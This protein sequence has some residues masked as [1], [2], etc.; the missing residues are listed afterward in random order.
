M[1]LQDKREKLWSAY[2]GE[3]C[4]AAY[5][6]LVNS[7]LPLVRFIVSRLNFK[8]PNHLEQEDLVSYGI[9][10]L[11]EAIKKF[12]WTRGVKFETYA[13][14]RIRGA[15]V[16][17]LR[18]EQ[19]APRSVADKLKA[20]QRAYQKFESEGIT[21]VS[22]EQLAEEMGISLE[23]LRDTMTEISQLSVV[24]L[25]EFLHGQEVDSISRAD[26]I[27]DPKSPNPAARVLEE[28]FRDYLAA[29]IEELPEKDRVVISLYY[30][31]ELTLR[32][33][34]MILEVSESRVS[35]LHAR[36]L[37]RLREKLNKYMGTSSVNGE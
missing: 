34:G 35:Q 14:Q 18:R 7:Y 17:A 37:M 22:E 16:D 29:A 15:V 30:Y 24:S 12:D 6:E 31:E 10:G 33:I 23:A 36:A 21:D 5:N 9:F 19:W 4:E 28:E 3:N 25:D 8:L 20:V 13:S 27:S 2:A 1:G 32:E 26:T 11:M